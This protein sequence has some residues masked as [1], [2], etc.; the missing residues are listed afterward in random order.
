MKKLSAILFILMFSVPAFSQFL[1]FGIKA[2]AETNTTPEYYSSRSLVGTNLDI[3]PVKNVSCGFHGGIFT[4]VKIFNLYV[5]PE[6]V[7]VS[8]SF[9]YS[10]AEFEYDIEWTPPPPEIKSQ[11]FNRLSVPILVG[12]KLGPLRV[13][14][15][16]AANIQIGTPKAFIDDPNFKDM[17]K[18]AVWG[19]Q[20]GIGIDILKKL[21]L[22]ARYAGSLGEK[23]GNEVTIGNQNFKL[24]HGQKSFLLSVGLM[25]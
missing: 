21:T 10:V 23:F 8:N 9:N 13:N 3:S 11:R 18:S 19:Y 1:S 12:M 20:A 17:Y 15:G 14:A 4:R 7:F 2:G 5:Q 16:P 22:D 25:F 6:V 24:D